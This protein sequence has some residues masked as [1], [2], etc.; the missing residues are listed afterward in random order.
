MINLQEGAEAGI[1]SP[2]FAKEYGGEVF[3]A[4][5]AIIGGFISRYQS[6]TVRLGGKPCKAL[7]PNP[8]PS[9]LNPKPRPQTHKP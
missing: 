7:N 3:K 9:T 8:K 2:T 5:S 6:S 1:F 4:R